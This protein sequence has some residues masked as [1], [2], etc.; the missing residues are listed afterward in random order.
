MV[1][2]VGVQQE[3]RALDRLVE[4]VYGVVSDGQHWVFL[5]LDSVKNLHRSQ[6][7]DLK[8]ETHNDALGVCVSSLNRQTEIILILTR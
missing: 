5:R 1:S 6:D 3:R 7:F 2:S 4:T 8:N